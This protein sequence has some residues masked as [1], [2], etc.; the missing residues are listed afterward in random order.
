MHRQL[1]RY[2]KTGDY[3]TNGLVQTLKIPIRKKRV[4]AILHAEEFLSTAD[5]MNIRTFLPLIL[6]ESFNGK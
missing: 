6:N 1:L 4:K 2:A 5:H 3:S